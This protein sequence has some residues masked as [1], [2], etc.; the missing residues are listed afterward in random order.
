MNE[1]EERGV[2]V[3]STVCAPQDCALC[4][5]CVNACPTGAIYLSE[6]ENGFEI[7]KITYDLHSENVQDNIVTEH[8]EMFSK[9]GIKIKALVAKLK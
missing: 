2:G 4:M 3:K 8:E 1:I 7:V 6:D 5:A 9:Q